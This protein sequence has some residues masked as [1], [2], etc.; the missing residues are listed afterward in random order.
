[1]FWSKEIE[2]HPARGFSPGAEWVEA[3]VTGIQPA[4]TPITKYNHFKLSE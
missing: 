3:G 4:I 2:T 1:M